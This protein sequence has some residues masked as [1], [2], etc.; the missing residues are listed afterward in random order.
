[1]PDRRTLRIP[2]FCIFLL[3]L[4][5]AAWSQTPTFQLL[6]NPTGSSTWVNYALSH[7]GKVMAAN[8]GGSI[9]RWTPD[10]PK[11]PFDGFSFVGPGNF[12]NSEIGISSDGTTIITARTG[13]DGNVDSAMWKQ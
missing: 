13:P 2:L 6:I 5:S 11:Y 7:D 3:T 4:S 10:T 12:L 1:M 9:Y 8:Y